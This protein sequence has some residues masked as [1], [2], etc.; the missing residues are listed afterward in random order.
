LKLEENYKDG[1]LDGKWTERHPNG[2]KWQ[3]GNY[4]D[5]NPEGKFTFWNEDGTI[6]KVEY[7]ENGD[8]LD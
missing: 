3:E 1:K 6:D 7:Y 5:G 8:L 2:Q 4:K